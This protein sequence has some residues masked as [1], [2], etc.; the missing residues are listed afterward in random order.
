MRIFLVGSV[1]TSHR[2]LTLS[3]DRLFSPSI[4]SS[5]FN[6][7]RCTLGLAEFVDKD[8]ITKEKAK[9]FRISMSLFMPMGLSDS[10]AGFQ[11]RGIIFYSL[12][13]KWY[14]K[15]SCLEVCQMK[16]LNPTIVF[17]EFPCSSVAYKS[18]GVELGRGGG[19]PKL[20][21]LD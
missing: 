3:V 15:I 13:L 16:F 1:Q 11:V 7:N 17:L 20:F 2:F 4:C 19:M 5:Q 18:C 6:G 14:I 12:L 9:L 21:S 8:V 10:S